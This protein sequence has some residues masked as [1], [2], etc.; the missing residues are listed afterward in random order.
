MLADLLASWLVG[1]IEHVGS[2]AV[3]GMPAKPIIDIMAPVKDLDTSRA[4]IP[5]LEK[6]EYCY[7]P[8]RADVEHWFC[9]PKPSART[10]HLHLVPY[11]SRVWSETLMFR[12][13]LRR[14]PAT[15]QKYIDLKLSLARAHRTDREAYTE[16]KT[17]FVLSIVRRSAA[18]TD[19]E[20]AP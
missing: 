4:A 10:H 14:E 15:A 16:G 8:Y 5:R 13:C 9:K 3:R 19:P 12:D 18:K 7:A 17:A 11:G 2:T 1:P 6:V 20:Y